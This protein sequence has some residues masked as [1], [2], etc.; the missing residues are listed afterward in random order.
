[1]AK[2]KIN[3]VSENKFTKEQIVA[4]KRYRANADLLNAILKDKKS[5]TLQEVDEKNIKFK[6]GKVKS[7]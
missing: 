3:N 1:M 6:K 7:C 4:S 2:S 5:Y